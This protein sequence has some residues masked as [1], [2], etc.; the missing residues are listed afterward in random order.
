MEIWRKLLILTYFL[1][2]TQRKR[3]MVMYDIVK[4][5]LAFTGIIKVYRRLIHEDVICTWK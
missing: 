5:L 4:S 2:G 1:K 3:I